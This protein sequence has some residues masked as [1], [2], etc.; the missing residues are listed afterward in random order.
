MHQPTLAALSPS[1]IYKNTR[2]TDG[3]SISISSPLP[4]HL[5]HHIFSSLLFSL[6]RQHAHHKLPRSKHNDQVGHS[7]KQMRRQAAVHAGQAF[8]A[9]HEAETLHEPRVLGPPRFGQG[10]LPQARAHHLVRV[11][12]ER[13]HELGGA[14]GARPRAPLEHMVARGFLVLAPRLARHKRLHLLVQDPLQRQL[15]AAQ[16][17][18]AQALVQAEKTFAPHNVHKTLPQAAVVAALGLVQL[19]AGLDQPDWVCGRRRDK[20]RADAGRQ[21]DPRR[22]GAA[23]EPRQ[24]HLL[25]GAISEEVDGPRRDHAHQVGAHAAEKR[26]GALA[27]V[28]GAERAAR[29]AQMLCRQHKRV[30]RLGRAVVR[31]VVGVRLQPCLDHVERARDNRP[32]HAAHAS[33]DKVDPFGRRRPCGAFH[34]LRGACGAGLFVRDEKRIQLLGVALDGP[35][36]VDAGLRCAVFI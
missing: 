24:K 25:A 5:Y 1:I 22:L 20:A 33:S 10:R 34:R 26:A 8:L 18:R 6:S 13:G 7:S 16:V 19:E 31:A 14:R 35:D 17:R 30:A 21:V 2:Q 27:A 28:D 15:R 12:D 36:S 4:P 9:R 23:I 29:L 32:H 11:G 3:I